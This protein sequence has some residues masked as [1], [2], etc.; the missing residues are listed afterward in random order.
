M[1]PYKEQ[2]GV[3]HAEE[4][5]NV[6]GGSELQETWTFQGNEKVKM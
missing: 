6:V 2:I 4:E 5:G 1:F 3:G